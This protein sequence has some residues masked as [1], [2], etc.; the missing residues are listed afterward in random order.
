M[1]YSGNPHVEKIFPNKSREGSFS[2]GKMRSWNN[3]ASRDE[4][5]V[6][7]GLISIKFGLILIK[8]NI[9]GLVEA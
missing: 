5:L 4:F 3:S 8:F 2:P 9:K 6:I 1:R 7:F